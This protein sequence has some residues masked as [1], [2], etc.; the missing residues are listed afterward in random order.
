MQLMG[1]THAGGAS[2]MSRD[3][4]LRDQIHETGS[5]DQPSRQPLRVAMRSHR[6]RVTIGKVEKIP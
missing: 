2:P 4:T 1:P 6:K 3:Q 5:R